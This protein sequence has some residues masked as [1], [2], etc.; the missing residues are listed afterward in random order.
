MQCGESADITLPLSTLSNQC[1]RFFHCFINIENKKLWEKKLIMFPVYTLNNGVQ[2]PAI[3][4]EFAAINILFI[5]IMLNM[6]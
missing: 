6:D 3:G 4:R 2:I 1:D 5:V